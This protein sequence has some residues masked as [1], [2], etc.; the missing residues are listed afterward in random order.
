MPLSLFPCA[1]AHAEASDSDSCK[2]SCALAAIQVRGDVVVSRNGPPYRPQ[3]TMVLIMGICKRVPLILGN[4]HIDVERSND[5]S[6]IH[7]LPR[8]R[9]GP[10]IPTP[11]PTTTLCT[12]IYSL[13]KVFL[14]GAFPYFGVHPRRKYRLFMSCYNKN[15]GTKKVLKCSTA[16]LGFFPPSTA[17]SVGSEGSGKFCEHRTITV[18]LQS[19]GMGTRFRV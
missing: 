17:A 18:T 7:L 6:G 8:V 10:D 4:S 15:P 13:W 14:G 2:S 5:V 12:G 16:I 19:A 3:Y 1:A 9:M 11:H